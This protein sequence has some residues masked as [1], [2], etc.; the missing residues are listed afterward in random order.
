MGALINDWLRNN[1]DLIHSD[2][3][4]HPIPKPSRVNKRRRAN[5]KFTGPG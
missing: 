1:I 4:R 5:S 2:S 3:S